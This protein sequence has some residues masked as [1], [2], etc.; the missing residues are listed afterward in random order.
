MLAVKTD[1]RKDS[2]NAYLE[3]MQDIKVRVPKEYF[4]KIK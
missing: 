3:K 2:Q 1:K 4:D